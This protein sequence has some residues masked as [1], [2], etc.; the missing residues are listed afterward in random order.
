[1]YKSGLI[2]GGVMFV[3]ALVITLL[4][5]YCVPCAALLIGF[6]G[7]YVAGVFAKPAAQ[8]GATKAGAI[9]G[10]LAGAGAILGEMIGTVINASVV[11]PEKVGQIL[12]SLGF[13]S[14]TSM[15]TGEYWA[16]QLGFN[17]CISLFSVALM[18]GLGALGGMVWWQ[19]N[20]KKQMPLPPPA[21]PFQ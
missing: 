2:F 21:V 6:A 5:P 16:I 11:G 7:G 4:F 15:T 1:M 12:Q 10:A 17:L 20:G 3:A 18:A 8:A 14:Y 13:P 19:V 9:A